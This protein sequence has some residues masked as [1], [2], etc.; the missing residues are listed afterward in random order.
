VQSRA[1][2]RGIPGIYG[3][4]GVFESSTAALATVTFC[5]AVRYTNDARNA[6]NVT[7]ERSETKPLVAAEG[8]EVVVLWHQRG[9][10]P[11]GERLDTEV[12]GLYEVRD[13]KLVRAQMFYF[14]ALAVADFLARAQAEEKLT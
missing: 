14:D 1:R 12:L 8:N 3:N 6:A 4:R 13:G 7:R 10:S 5:V 2:R 11:G 9:L